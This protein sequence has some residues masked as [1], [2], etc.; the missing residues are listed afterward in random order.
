MAGDQ[1]RWYGVSRYRSR[2]MVGQMLGQM[3]GP[4]IYNDLGCGSRR[5]PQ[6]AESGA[7]RALIRAR[8]RGASKARV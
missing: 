1:T 2:N 7:G 8:E 5:R 6:M 4:G 3:A